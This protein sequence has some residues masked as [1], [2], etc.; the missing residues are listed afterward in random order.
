MKL[1]YN[2]NHFKM[3]TVRSGLQ[4]VTVHNFKTT[5]KTSFGVH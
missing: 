2:V 3:N 4:K 5:F 1:E